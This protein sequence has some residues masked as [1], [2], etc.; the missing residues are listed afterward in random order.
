MDSPFVLLEVKN[1]RDSEETPTAMEQVFAAL[2]ASGGR[3]GLLSRL[4]GSRHVPKYFSFEL[5]SVN[6][7]IH[8]F[9]GVPQHAQTYVESQLTAHYPKIVLSSSPDY[10]PHFLS[11]PHAMG[12]LV[13]TNSFYYPLKTYKDIK[14]LD[15]MASILGQIA[16]LPIGEAAAVQ[17]RV[18]PAGAGWQRTGAQVVAQG[19]PD[20]SSTTG[21]TKTHPHARLIESKISQVG[22]SAAIRIVA[23]AA[24]ETRA[25]E[26]L[27]ALGGTFGVY[28]LGEGNG[29][30][31]VEPAFWQKKKLEHGFV[32][33]NGDVAPRHQ[34]VNASELASLWHPPGLATS[35]IK[36]ISWGAHL[37]GEA[38][39]NL[40]IATDNEEEKRRINFFARTEFKN[41]PAT[42]GIKKDDRRK[43]VYIVG[44]TGTGKSTMIANMAINDMK[45]G[46]GVAVVD[47]HGDLCDILLDYVPSHRINDVA[48]LDPS[49]IEYPFHLNPLEVK[50]AAY[51]ELVSSGIVSIFYKL[52]HLSWGPRLEYILRNTI[53]TLLSVPNSTLLQ[54][55]E[56][57][58]NEHYRA[59]VVER[60]PDQ[61]LKNFWI[62]EFAK[63]SPQFRSEAVS[64]IL[65]KVGQFLSSQTIRNIVGSPVSTIDLESM[66]ND[67][68]IV[69]V[70][71]SQGKLGEDSSALLGAMIITKI[72][73]AA[74]NRVYVA[75]G[76]R[77]DFYLYVDE[78][79]NFATTSFIK[80]L[81]EARKYRLDLT[82]ANQYIGQIDEDVQKA[83]FGNAGSIASFSVGATDARILAKE[84]GL[85]YKEEELV[86]LGNYEIV[87]KLSIDNHTTN[88]FS[89]TT[90]PLPK[91]R[92]QNREK[93]IRSSRERYTKKINK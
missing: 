69:I 11:L 68:K 29:L 28:T 84:F 37:T 12:Q 27:Y 58:T 32:E 74:M 63:M 46:E 15:I 34:V 40:P 53:L 36:N 23:V 92:N 90:L 3:G 42:F 82:L 78:F 85:Q 72:Q 5:V 16:K 45:N 9:V 75:E 33:R 8:F 65:N 73:L 52:Y 47:P 86:G 54:V 21:R 79:Q 87:T 60:M 64:P 30:A 81:S 50:N 20:P 62:N 22:F 25:K 93:V 1:A 91:S 13:F 80:I 4:F 7:R 43:H 2:G 44:K 48:Y 66:M 41:R 61:V 57:L 56:L 38:P 88:P 55:P 17:F 49:D 14:D 71:L 89:A 59:N 67:G 77:R 51:K 83:I 76:E 19:I 39:E 35:M 26:L 6:S 31:I 18:S 70:N 24:N 10:A